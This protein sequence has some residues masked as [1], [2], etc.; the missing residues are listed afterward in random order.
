MIQRMYCGS[1]FIS[2]LFGS[3]SV[4]LFWAYV[5][6]HPGLLGNLFDKVEPEKRPRRVRPTVVTPSAAAI[7]NEQRDDRIAA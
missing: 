3:A 7:D 1:H 4:G 2:D 6:N 5:C